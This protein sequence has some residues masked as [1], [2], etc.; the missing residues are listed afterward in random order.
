MVDRTRRAALAERAARAGAVVARQRFRDQLAVETKAGKT[1]LVTESDRDAQ[2][3]ILAT[4]H[5]EFPDD[6]FVCEETATPPAMPADAF[7][8]RETVPDTEPAWVI[9][10]IDGTANYVRETQFWGTSVAAV[11]DG[12]PVGVATY[13]PAIGDLYAAGP[14][15]VTRDG[16]QISV[17]D[18]NDPETFAVGLLGWWPT[19][20][21]G[22]YADLFHAAATRFGDLRRLGSMQG[23]LALVAAGS[24]DAAFMPARPHPWDAIAGVHLI[25][26]AGGTVTDIHGDPWTL[27]SQGLVVSNGA[28]HETVR[29]VL[30]AAPTPEIG[31]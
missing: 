14:D 11:V 17:S 16:T 24:L 8:M 12:S 18:R 25:R 15:S 7:D 5:D 20:R 22:E 2:R 30:R 29:E 13:L 26:Q 28:A 4:I 31:D 21:D 23:S 1:D 27:D 10:P 19:K 3:Q 6:A 9:D